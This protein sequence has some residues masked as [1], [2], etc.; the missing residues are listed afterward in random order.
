[1]RLIPQTSLRNWG[2]LL[3][4]IATSLAACAAPP[5]VAQP[6]LPI[7]Q[8]RVGM[9]GYGLTVFHG[10]EIEPFNVE[11]VSVNANETPGMAVIWVRC[12]DERMVFTGPVQGMSGSPIYLWDEQGEH[13]IGE[14]GKLIGAFAFGYGD[15]NDCI[16]G[17]QPIEH[18]RAVGQRATAK[19]RPELASL[20][21]A[22]SG[23]LLMRQ[24]QTVANDSDLSP[25]TRARLDVLTKVYENI[26]P[27]TVRRT[28]TAR[29]PLG[30]GQPGQ[31]M[32]MMMPMAVASPEIAAVLRPTLEPMGI[33]PFAIDPSSLGG[34]PP[35]GFDTDNVELA[36]GS[37]LVVPF[38]WGDADLMGIGT[39]TDVLPDGTVLGFGHA[40]DGV[41]VTAVPMA[42]GYVH[43]IVSLRTISYKRGGTLEIA[44]TL[45]QDEQAA[46]AGVDG[47]QFTT[48]PVNVK[49][50]IEGQ[51]QREYSYEVL[52]HPTLTPQI[53]AA[54][55]VQSATAIQEAP[56]RNTMS[57][58]ATAKFSG[59]RELSLV[60]ADINA[61]GMGA[62]SD[63]VQ[64][65]G[66]ITQNPFEK[67]SLE[68]IDVE[69]NI[70]YGLDAWQINSVRLDRATAA[71]GETV[72][73]L[74]EFMGLEEKPFTRSYP[75]TIPEDAPEGEQQIVIGDGATYTQFSLASRPYLTQIDSVD[76]LIAVYKE[77]LN[78]SPRKLYTVVP[79]T[80]TGV[81]I[82]GQSL[83]S[84]PGSRAV[85]LA[86]GNPNAVAYQ[87]PH[88]ESFDTERL[89]VGGGQ[90]KLTIQRPRG[91]R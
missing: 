41:G 59:D 82:D 28:P 20:A 25:L 65:V 83:P 30:P 81:A 86:S 6:I 67:V 69:I 3:V 68:G 11:V 5:E 85:I 34:P 61:G 14:G 48:A 63:M 52:N 51:P 4:L 2:T 91:S 29:L 56:A 64:L 15:T 73:A 38:A 32:R 39:V 79:T 43:F 45:V 16:V 74:V 84:L 70:N 90:V 31:T 71:P 33:Q 22:G 24:L 47:Q 54:V 44:G 75:I 78:V 80:R 58:T 89:I 21:P 72:N 66:S 50:N 7:D 53:A 18:M 88:V 1:M 23:Y 62:A 27:A 8:V 42:T 10:T 19:E 13:T 46:V 9:K 55:I 87:T 57:Y 77:L 17:V 76:D 40:M 12:S 26:T 37:A 49:V 35:K 60:S 36:P